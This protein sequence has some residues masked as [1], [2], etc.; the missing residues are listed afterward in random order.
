[1][2]INDKL[3]AFMPSFHVD[4]ASVNAISVKAFNI[5]LLLLLLILLLFIPLLFPG[6][7]PPY[8]WLLVR[9]LN[10]NV[11]LSIVSSAV[12][13]A[14]LM[15]SL[16]KSAHVRFASLFPMCLQPPARCPT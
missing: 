2:L 3:N 9:T 8:L 5:L 14:T 1:M 13:F 15:F 6:L 11:F 12:T 10:F 16:T 7:I 4:D